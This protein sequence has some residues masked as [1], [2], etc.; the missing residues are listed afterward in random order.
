MVPTRQC[1]SAQSIK[2][3]TVHSGH[4]PATSHRGWEKEVSKYPNKL[5][6]EDISGYITTAYE[7][8]WWLGYVLLINE[9]FD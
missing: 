8:K 4:I 2:C 1:P 3:P 5:K 7:G 9:E 6:L